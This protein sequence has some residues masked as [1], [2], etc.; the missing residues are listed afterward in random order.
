MKER[1]AMAHVNYS[2][3]PDGFRTEKTGRFYLNYGYVVVLFAFVIIL[4]LWG[5]FNSFGIY[6][7]SMI[8]EFGWTRASTSGAFSLA[9]FLSGL[10]AAYMGFLNDRFG[11]RVVMSLCGLCLGFGCIFMSQVETLWH[12]Y[13]FFGIIIGFAMGGGFIP[14]ISTVARW[15]TVHRGLMTGIVASGVGAGAL[16]VPQ[17][18][19]TLLSRFGWRTSYIITGIGALVIVIAAAQFLKNQPGPGKQNAADEEPKTPK[20]EDCGDQSASLGEALGSVPFWLFSLTGFCYGYNLFSL[21]VH[22]VPHAVDLGIPPGLAAGLLSTYGGFSIVGKI[23]FGRVLD[24]INSKK[25]MFIGF[26]M[27]MVAFLGLVFAERTWAIF[28]SV[29][30]FGFFYGACTVSHSPMTAT[31]F[32][33][34]SHGLIM[35]VFAISVTIGG[36]LGP[37]LTGAIFDQTGSYRTAFAICAAV[38]VTGMAG[39]AGIRQMRL[40]RRFRGHC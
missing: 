28:T 12:F 31:L 24:K 22:V 4:V 37:F 40:Q 14:L 8:S 20:N 11:P 15:F 2:K 32:G 18:S 23:L 25:T 5:V 34:K 13:L 39:T 21:T 9:S 1:T 16:I 27:M 30:V 17:I 3:D 29:G 33:L 35:G 10:V 19:N 36:A 26:S 7:K 38:G 6:F